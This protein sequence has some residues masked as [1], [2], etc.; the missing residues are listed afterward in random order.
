MTLAALQTKRDEILQ[1]IG[2][3]RQ[4]FGERSVEF[5]DAKKALEVLDA[6][7]AKATVAGKTTAMPR[8]SFASF[9]ND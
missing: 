5:S 4:S 8:T 2:V 3:V 9:S 7:I 1:Q 6:E